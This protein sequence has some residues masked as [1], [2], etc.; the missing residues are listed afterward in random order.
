MELVVMLEMFALLAVRV[1]VVILEILALIAFRLLVVILETIALI[2]VRVLV[3]NV[4]PYMDERDENPYET[5][6]ESDE[7]PTPI[8]ESCEPS[9]W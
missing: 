3:L 9:P 1:L 4:C 6:D 8:F 5:M 7:I 2:A